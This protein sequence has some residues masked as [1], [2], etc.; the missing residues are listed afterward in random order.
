MLKVSFYSY[1]G[2][3]GRST[4]LWNT[5]HCLMN[6]VENGEKKWMPSV[7]NPY[8]IVDADIDSAGSTFLY[9]GDEL[10]K[11]ENDYLSVQAR[12]KRPELTDFKSATD[13]VK[14]QYFGKMM[15]IGTSF[16]LPESEN[17]AILL[18]GANL[19]KDK[20]TSMGVH[21]TDAGNEQE[22]N[23]SLNITKNCRLCGAKAIFF[24]TPS[25]TQFFAR[26]SIK[27]SDVV[28]CCMRPTSQFRTGTLGQ[29]KEFLKLD[30][31]HD[32]RRKYIITPT[33]VCTDPDQKFR[34][35][36]EEEP[37]IYPQKAYKAIME[38]F[39]DGAAGNREIEDKY[40]ESVV[41]DML[42]IP[43]DVS[44]DQFVFGI[45]EVKRFKWQEA[46]LG[47]IK[48]QCIEELNENDKLA[49]ERYE[50]L[51]NKIVYYGNK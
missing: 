13:D 41:L 7:K 50:L 33:A 26:W 29:L 39:Y 35:E 45:P 19:D 3:S 17:A 4:T 18:I 28:V 40:K 14:R 27:Q 34:L 51:A 48:E 47:L 2:G 23:L 36:L 22:S 15:S 16:G 44:D 10:F 11:Q 5:V 21:T 6:L 31:N 12:T 30:Q 32:N 42:K 38:R 37:F 46:C 9:K 49:L 1:K 25:G 20:L 43:D 24:D 8:I